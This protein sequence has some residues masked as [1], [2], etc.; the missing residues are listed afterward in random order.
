M[1][2]NFLDPAYP[3]ILNEAGLT[4]K[5]TIYLMN[6]SGNDFSASN[7]QLNIHKK[8]QVQIYFTRDPVEL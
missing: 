5:S 7:Q 1:F 2:F 8:N 6:K 3:L 4:Q